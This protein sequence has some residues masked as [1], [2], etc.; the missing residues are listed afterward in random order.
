MNRREF[1][2]ASLAGT[3]VCML[4]GGGLLRLRGSTAGGDL[5]NAAFAD[6]DEEL[7]EARYYTKLEHQDVLCR[8]CPRECRVG[9]RERGYCGVRENRRGVYYTLVYS[10]LCAEHVDPIEKK[11]FFHFHPG[12]FAYSIATAGCNMNCKYCQNWDISQVRPEQ[13]RSVSRTPGECAAKAKESGALSV[14]Y[15]YSEPT[16]FYEYMYDTCGKARAAGLKNIMV[17]AGFISKEPLA[18]LCG[19]LDAVKIDLKAFSDSFYKTICRGKRQPVLDAMKTLRTRGL[20]ME[21]VYLVVPTLN[22]SPEEMRQLCRWALGELGPDVPLHLSR[23]FPTYLLT[24][25]PPT[26][27]DTLERLHGIA[28]EEGLHY[29]YIGNVPGHAM[30]STYCHACGTRVIKRSGYN[31]TIERLAKGGLCQACGTKIPGIWA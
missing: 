9:D 14:C 17:S 4:G 29:V 18:D 25:L 12:T 11:P 28:R 2:T 26:P 7:V 16:V 10:R 20:W 6:Q 19:V 13:V 8:L 1:L 15:T 3:G 27:V 24:N 23:F 30:E 5:W 21:I 22:D 31:V